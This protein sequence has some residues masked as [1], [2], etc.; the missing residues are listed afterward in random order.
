MPYT[1]N[2]TDNQNTPPITVFDNTSNT[3]TSLTFPGRN[4]T[5]YGQTIAENFL[6]LL[7]N[8]ASASA[9]PNPT[10]GQVWFN[11]DPSVSS[12]LIF[13]GSDW[14]SASGVQKSP[15]EPGVDQSKVGELWV[16]TVNQQ[17]YV[18]S[19]TDWILVGPNFSTGLKSGLNVEQVIDSDN[20]TRVVLSVYVED[21]PIIII[22]KDSFTPKLIIPQFPV[23]RAGVNIAAPDS[24]L[25]PETEIYQGGFL[26]KLY[27]TSTSADGLRVG[28]LVVES[29]KFLRTDISNVVE[30]PFNIKNDSG[31]TL[32]VDSTF[33]LSTS[34]T[35]AKL[36]NSQPGSSIDL[37]L[38]SSG[39][40]STVLRVINGK[41]GINNLSPGESLDV[42]GNALINGRLIVSDTTATTNLNNG[43]VRISGGVAI[44]KNL[45]VNDGITSNST[46][47][48]TDVLPQ[49]TDTYELGSPVRRWNSIRT[50]TL[51]A[52]TI[53]GVLT[54]SISGNAGTATSLQQQTTFSIT[55]DVTSSSFQFNGIAGGTSKVFNTSISPLFIS[56][57]PRVETLISPEKNFSLNTDV[58]LI[59]RDSRSGLLQV[60][61]DTFVGDLGVPIGAILPFA[62][63]NVPTG[64]LLCDGTELLIEKY[65]Q[66][67]SII[68]T[69]YNGSSPLQGASGS[70][71]RLPDLRGRFPLGK[72]NM[73]N[74]EQVQSSTGAVVDGG[75]GNA[76]RIPGVEPDTL[77]GAGGGSG[78]TLSVSNLPNHEHSMQGSTGQQYYAARVDTA[79]P[80][81]S[82]AFLS[83]GGTT[84]NRVQYLPSS[85]GIKTGG[86]TGQPYSVVNPFLTLNY[87]IRSGTPSF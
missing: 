26:P 80:L 76:D 37:Q 25:I 58:V 38:S 10:V 13:D 8:F 78:Y 85:G 34:T 28:Q 59:Y 60:S 50:K 2:Y 31:L 64:F 30:A 54:G 74:G 70:T 72:D 7:E 63:S 65:N 57:K 41:V 40:V 56:S 29:G 22:S 33:I 14:K 73:D 24:A 21:K 23:I 4:V 5:G 19:G 62:G 86:V 39:L 48:L 44:S 16:D 45:L 84:A 35:A 36:Y 1:V 47:F 46:S 61:R 52:D 32:G 77:G 20:I 27:G 49:T 66:L 11:S 9:P 69:T 42:T 83:T 81:D 43:A 87:I 75:G 3:D 71:F 6:H 53:Q 51:I 55:G 17:L 68:G 12:L 79:V 15:V 18:F 67:Y 82:G